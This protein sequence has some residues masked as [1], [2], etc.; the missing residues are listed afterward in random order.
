MKKNTLKKVFSA[1]SLTA[2]AASAVSLSLLNL[3]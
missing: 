3:K 1:L 2:V